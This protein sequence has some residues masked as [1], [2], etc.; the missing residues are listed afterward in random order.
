MTIFKK[1][2]TKNKKNKKNECHKQR[3]KSTRKYETICLVFMFPSWVK[4]LNLSRKVCF[5]QF[6]AEFS[7]KHKYVKAI[8]IYHLEVLTTLFQKIIWFTGVGTTLYE[9]LA[10]KISKNMLTQQK[11]KEII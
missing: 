7:Q 4:A 8:Y 10:M 9:I 11:R 2:K 1:N 3:G 6:C 5:L